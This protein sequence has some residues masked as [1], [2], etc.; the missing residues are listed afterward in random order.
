MSFLDFNIS[1]KGDRCTNLLTASSEVKKGYC[2]SCS[3]EM[4]D[5][6][7][8]IIDINKIK[9]PVIAHYDE[10]QDNVIAKIYY[11]NRAHHD[12]LNADWIV[13]DNSATWCGIIGSRHAKIRQEFFMKGLIGWQYI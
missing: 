11:P 9:Q 4:E 8:E 3:E 7:T 1:C 5:L 12:S 6:N 10:M 13:R 2:Y